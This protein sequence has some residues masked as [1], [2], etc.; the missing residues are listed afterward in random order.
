VTV[1]ALALLALRAIVD[2]PFGSALKAVRE[3][4]RR[5]RYIGIDVRLHQLMAFVISGF[6]SGLAGGLFAFYNGSVFPDF[7]FFT[8]SFEPLVVTLLG[9][10]GSFF[11]PLV[12]AFGFKLL[13]W[14]ISREW[15]VYWPLVLG[16]VVI[17]VVILLPRGFVG[18]A[19]G[20]LWTRAARQG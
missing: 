7:A 8:K 20:R 11:G 18:L 16:S 12:G 14:L 17:A 3:N 19:G 2:S 6:F 15:P 4:P 1:V 13:E 5:A 9:G 10:V